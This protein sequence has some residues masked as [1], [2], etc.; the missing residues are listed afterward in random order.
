MVGGCGV[1]QSVCP[2]GTEDIREARLKDDPYQTKDLYSK[3]N[4]S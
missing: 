2:C 1:L 3:H 4:I